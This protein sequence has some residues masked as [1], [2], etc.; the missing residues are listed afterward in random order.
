[1]WYK[2]LKQ[3]PKSYK[4]KWAYCYDSRKWWKTYKEPNDTWTLTI[5]HS[6]STTTMTITVID[7]ANKTCPERKPVQIYHRT[8][9]RLLLVPMLHHQVRKANIIKNHPATIRQQSRNFRSKST[10]T[11]LKVSMKFKRWISRKISVSLISKLFSWRVRSSMCSKRGSDKF[12]S[13]LESFQV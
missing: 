1:M 6:H 4:T 13:L 12:L 2:G 8:S 9:S 10:W 3:R 11:N 7:P 5:K